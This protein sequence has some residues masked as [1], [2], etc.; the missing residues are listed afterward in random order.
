MDIGGS[1][2]FYEGWGPE[3]I[4]P[5]KKCLVKCGCGEKCTTDEQKKCYLD[6]E[7]K[8][9][10]FAKMPGYKGGAEGE[11]AFV[12]ISGGWAVGIN[13]KSS[14]VEKKL[15]WEFIK[16]LC[17]K[18][19]LA[20]YAAKYGKVCP[21]LDAVEVE[22]YAKD[23]YLSKLVEYLKFT[24]FRDALPGY[25]KVSYFVQKVTEDII[26]KGITPDEALEEFYSLL[27]K[28]FGKDKVEVLPVKK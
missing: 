24:D 17:S 21:R 5:L 20:R 12:T 13:A 22:A 14:D 2:E 18:E 15:A 19:L 28:E 23:P 10:G 16:I 11:P 9:I 27:V 8:I 1:W 7:W 4:A 26:T 3:G 25:S 6:C